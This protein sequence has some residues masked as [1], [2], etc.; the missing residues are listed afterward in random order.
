VGGRGDLQNREPEPR[1]DVGPDQLGEVMRIG[2]ID[3]VQHDQPRPPRESA[4]DCLVVRR[5]LGL[6]RLQ[7]ADRVPTRLERRAV[8][9]MGEHR[10][11]LDVA[12]ELQAQPAPAAGT[13]HQTGHVRDREHDVSRLDDTEVGH[14]RR[15]RV[16]GNLRA[17]SRHRS[18]QRGL[19]GVR[20]PHQGHVSDGLELQHR[21]EGFAGLPQQG[22]PGCL[23]TRGGQ[24]GVAQPATPA[25]GENETGAGADQVDDDLTGGRI[26][27]QGAVRNPDDEITAVGAVAVRARAGTPVAGVLMGVPVDVEQRRHAGVDQE[28]H[29]TAAPA[30]T[31]VGAAERLELLA[32]DRGAAVAPGATGG[33]QG[34]TVDKGRGHAEEVRRVRPR[35]RRRS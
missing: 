34:G 6:D 31:A 18:D 9:D 27:D 25:A 20:E 7:V 10:A 24:R 12:E 5:Q 4:V 17:R 19:S 14:Q 2:D 11:P 35:R 22:E 32:V 26:P 21:F 23:A 8:D 30:V 16:V 29:I 28:D 33:M 13:R 15:E 1:G 3:L